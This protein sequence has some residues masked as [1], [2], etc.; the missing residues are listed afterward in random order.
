MN[1]GEVVITTISIS[2]SWHPIPI[3]GCIGQSHDQ[4]KDLSYHQQSEHSSSFSSTPSTK[5]RF[6]SPPNCQSNGK[7][8]EMVSTLRYLISSSIG[9]FQ[10]R[11]LT[12]TP[13]HPIL[14]AELLLRVHQPT[15]EI[16]REI[17]GEH[18][19]HE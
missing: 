14:S 15:K 11:W 18:R 3:I 7:G 17:S 16:A 5:D 4:S 19:Q 8:G 2:H 12:P 13:I 1:G 10:K 6:P 9:E